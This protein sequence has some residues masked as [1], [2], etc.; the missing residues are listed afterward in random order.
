MRSPLFTAF[1]LT[2]ATAAMAMALPANAQAATDHMSL[3]QKLGISQ[4]LTPVSQILRPQVLAQLSAPAP[5]PYIQIASAST[6]ELPIAVSAPA[7]SLSDAA[8]ASPFS[9]SPSEITVQPSGAAADTAIQMAKADAAQTD[10]Q[11]SDKPASEPVTEKKSDDMSKAGASPWGKILKTYI[12]KDGD[13]NRF[14]YAALAGNSADMKALGAYI[15]DL[16]AKSPGGMGKD[17]A[18]AYW[19]NLYN[20]VT[21]QVVTENWPVKSIKQIKSGTF[22]PGPWDK[23]LV[24]VNGKPMTLNNIEHD[25]MRANYKEP[26]IHYMVNCASVGCPNLMDTPWSAKTLEADLNA[27]AK[28][29]INSP[30][31]AKVSGGKLTVSSIF[32]WYKED[33]GGNDAGVIAHLKQYADSDLKAAL[34]GVSKISKDQYDWDVNAK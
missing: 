27:A 9:A 4:P 17:E 10:E 22:K 21:V 20:A 18:L 19:A 23:N 25:T 34:D 14:N 6:P 3:F 13:L 16:A 2:T 15:D 11:M 26:R 32:K 33:F 7:S 29:F 5:A 28:S 12:S 30:R 24:T 8:P 1:T 31:G